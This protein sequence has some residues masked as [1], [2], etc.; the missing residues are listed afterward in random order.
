M[1][2]VPCQSR[3]MFGFQ[4]LAASYARGGKL[5]E[6]ITP[7]PRI[8]SGRGSPATSNKQNQRYGKDEQP[9]RTND[10]GQQ[11]SEK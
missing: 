7:K 5:D 2:C 11:L 1:V 4:L 10:Q 8:E 3:G 6:L 9:D